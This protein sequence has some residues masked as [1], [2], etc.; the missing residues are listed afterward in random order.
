MDRPAGQFA[1]RAGWVFWTLYLLLLVLGLSAT[2]ALSPLKPSYDGRHFLHIAAGTVFLTITPFQFIG[3]V[4]RRYPSYHRIAG[5]VLVAAALLAIASTFALNLTPLGTATL[6][7]QTTLLLVWLGS[8]LAAIWCIRHGDVVWHQRHMARALVAGAYF[9]IIRLFDR[10]IGADRALAFE[11]E[12]AVRFANSDWLGWLVP[13]IFVEI[14][15][16]LTTGGR[17]R[18]RPGF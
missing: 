13:M 10:L 9:L 17:G 6:P 8:L 12:P 3:A 18:P 5:R 14:F 4:R 11:A 15:M 2:L 7:S 16:V 1:E